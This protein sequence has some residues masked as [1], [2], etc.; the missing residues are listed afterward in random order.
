MGNTRGVAWFALFALTGCATVEAPHSVV[1]QLN[2]ATPK[3]QSSACRQARQAALIY[4]EKSGER[5]GLGV[6]LGLLLGPVGLPLAMAA[7][8]SQAEKR[9]ATVALLREACEG[10]LAPSAGSS[11]TDVLEAGLSSLADLR[12]KGM[13]TEHEYA[14]RRAAMVDQHLSGTLSSATAGKSGR[15]SA[16]T[17][18]GT[19]FILRDLEP[20][21]TAVM[22]ESSWAVGSVG[23]T[24]STFNDGALVWN[25]ADLSIQAGAVAGTRLSGFDPRE[26]RPG[27]RVRVR[28]HPADYADEVVPVEIR[29]VDFDR[30]TRPGGQ[31]HVLKLALSGWASNEGPYQTPQAWRGARME[32]S[33]AIDM[34]TGLILQARIECAYPTYAMKRDLVDVLVAAASTAAALKRADA[35]R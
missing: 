13:I 30:I 10:E 28:F 5:I 3:Y 9:K 21:S 22:R 31:A 2:S 33:L 4:D 26:L 19:R 35:A 27:D 15:L 23:P 14:T 1:Q 24:A 16:P 12:A 6:G 25:L 17:S 20:I 18:M 7:D 34:H 11:P 8:A 29:V 32:G